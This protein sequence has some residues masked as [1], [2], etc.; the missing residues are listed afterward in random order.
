[1]LK[2][3][4]SKIYDPIYKRLMDDRGI[5]ITN[6]LMDIM[7]GIDSYIHLW[8]NLVKFQNSENEIGQVIIRMV[9]DRFH[10][11][12]VTLTAENANYIA[13]IL[14]EQVKKDFPGNTEKVNNDLK[15]L[16]LIWKN[17]MEKE[18]NSNTYSLRV[19]NRKKR[20]ILYINE[21]TEVI[22]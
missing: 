22:P 1:M 5:H 9:V 4:F 12:D 21:L 17:E 16:L 20:F 7:T 8:S 6:S 11:T 3:N 19:L 2:D 13:G 10:K 18:I 14:L 15:N